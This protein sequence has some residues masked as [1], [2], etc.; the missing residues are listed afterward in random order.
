MEVKNQK[1]LFIITNIIIL[2]I[3]FSGHLLAVKLES[4]AL[5]DGLVKMFPTLKDEKAPFIDF[6]KSGDS[7]YEQGVP[8]IIWDRPGDGEGVIQ[9]QEILDAVVYKDNFRYLRVE[10]LQE[11]IKLLDN[12]GKAGGKGIMTEKVARSYMIELEGLVLRRKELPDI[13]TQNE[14]QRVLSE[15]SIVIQ[16][17]S[18]QYTEEADKEASATFKGDLEKF[19]EG[20]DV[21]IKTEDEDPMKLPLD[22]L[23]GDPNQI[24]G[25]MVRILGDEVKNYNE[26]YISNKTAVFS[27]GKIGGRSALNILVNILQDPKFAKEINYTIHALGMI[28]EECTPEVVEKIGEYLEK[29]TDPE[30]KSSAI[31]TLGRVGNKKSIALLKKYVDSPPAN[32]EQL[33][34]DGLEALVNIAENERQK[35]IASAEIVP[36]FRDY[37]KSS[38]QMLA[39][40]S[41]KGLALAKNTVPFP[42]ILE[43]IKMMKDFPDVKVIDNIL[44]TIEIVSRYNTATYRTFFAGSGE[45]KSIFNYLVECFTGKYRGYFARNTGTRIGIAGL[46]K[47]VTVAVPYLQG[48]DLLVDAVT[49]D[50]PRVRE[51]AASLLIRISSEYKVSASSFGMSTSSVPVLTYKAVT[52]KKNNPRLLERGLQIIS[53]QTITSMQIADFYFPHLSDLDIRIVRQAIRGLRC[54]LSNQTGEEKYYRPGQ[55]E[56]VRVLIAKNTL[57]ADIRITAVEVAGLIG[58]SDANS[59][60][61]NIVKTLYEILQDRNSM[62]DLKISAVLAFPRLK[63]KQERSH[64][65]WVALK[66]AV[67]DLVEDDDINIRAAVVESLRDLNMDSPEI[68]KALYFALSDE[69]NITIYY[70]ILEAI[71]VINNP[72]SSGP[73]RDFLVKE[74]K[75]DPRIKKITIVALGNCGDPDMTDILIDALNDPDIKN[76]ARRGLEQIERDEMQ[77]RVKQRIRTITDEKVKKELESLLKK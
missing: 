68:R 60:G 8:E 28:G 51:E 38:N 47:E 6:D 25:S 50:N 18:K 43:L 55:L 29:S 73:L 63:E 3:F 5:N 31:K 27:I 64:Q 48:I 45:S 70:N 49:D 53:K 33:R 10:Q 59:T 58:F 67:V 44:E 12:I 76:E 39:A 66:D 13:V 2:M 7:R 21:V 24:K 74:K 69:K 26:R 75:L 52:R 14:R 1:Y 20:M 11:I 41:I 61:N 30:V 36:I 37:T 35:G 16:R 54:I 34:G 71:R 22:N 15:L 32:M 62:P 72:E 17:M 57:P 19:K 77:K 9:A 4:N 23:D 42:E 40:Y 65:H 46:I 56:L